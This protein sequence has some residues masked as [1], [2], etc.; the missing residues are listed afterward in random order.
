MDE[1]CEVLKQNGATFYKNPNDCEY[2]K[3]LLNGF[4]EHEDEDNTPYEQMSPG[5]DSK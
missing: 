3:T 5:W 1:R 2:V 4:G